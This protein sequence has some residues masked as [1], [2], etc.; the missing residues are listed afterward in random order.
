MKPTLLM[1]GLSWLLVAVC[2]MLAIVGGAGGMDQWLKWVLGAV[3]LY[4]LG[5]AILFTRDR[6]RGH[7]FG[8]LERL[9]WHAHGHDHA[10]HGK[11][12]H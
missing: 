1:I 8:L 10:T 11:I 7:S 4:V 3:S 6:L 12:P 2:T 9:H 5:L